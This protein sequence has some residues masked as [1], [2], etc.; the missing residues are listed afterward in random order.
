MC[1]TLY[2][3]YD[4]Y[5]AMPPLNTKLKQKSYGIV[6]KRQKFIYLYEWWMWLLVLFPWHQQFII[7]STDY[8]IIY[9]KL[10]FYLS[11]DVSQ[12]TQHNFQSSVGCFWC[13]L[14]NMRWLRW[15]NERYWWAWDLLLVLLGPKF[16]HSATQ[17][18]L[19]HC[20][21]TCQCCTLIRAWNKG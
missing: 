9:W 8:P 18:N 12:S 4:E 7:Q 16:A 6:A 19:S 5:D 3:E 1:S 20:N 11:G 21:L 17:G 14:V 13:K 2:T 10:Y 15:C